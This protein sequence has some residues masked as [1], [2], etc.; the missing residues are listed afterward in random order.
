VSREKGEATAT[1]RIHRQA[2]STAKLWECSRC[3]A[4]LIARNLSHACGAYSVEKFLEGKTDIGR[5]LFKRFVALIAQCGPYELAP[6]KTRVAFMASVRF[7][8]V[9]RIGRDFLDVHFVLP[10]TI[11]SPRL[12][13]VE[14]VGKQ[15]VHH[16][17]LRDRRD[18][19]RE[20]AD[21]LCQS[22]IEYGQR[23]WLTKNEATNSAKRQR[24]SNVDPLS[25][26]RSRDSGEQ[27]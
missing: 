21:W 10:R 26:S 19:N 11:D 25:T 20:L 23:G 4:K 22:Y 15:Y 24:E 12:R 13:R 27:R 8:S 2:Q 1:Q 5:D 7:A 3:G 18:F 6:A 9:N 16:L 14:H 17:R